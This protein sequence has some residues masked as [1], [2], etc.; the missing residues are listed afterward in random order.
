MRVT[1]T[2]DRGRNKVVKAQ[3]QV[4]DSY[5]V[6]TQVLRMCLLDLRTHRRILAENLMAF[7][8]IERKEKD[9]V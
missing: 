5:M 2:L 1:G 6:L 8:L 3:S 4:I 9:P 7:P